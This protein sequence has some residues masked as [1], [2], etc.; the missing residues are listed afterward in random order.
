MVQGTDINISGG[1]FTNVAGD[2]HE[3]KNTTVILNDSEK[4]SES[5]GFLKGQF[6]GKF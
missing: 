1:K 2:Y 4:S 6:F 5:L 3:H